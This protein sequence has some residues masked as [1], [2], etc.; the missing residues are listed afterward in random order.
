MRR[1]NPRHIAIP[2]VARKLGQDLA[3]VRRSMPLHHGFVKRKWKS[4]ELDLAP[5]TP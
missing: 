5:N 4:A 1:H 3:K 2:A